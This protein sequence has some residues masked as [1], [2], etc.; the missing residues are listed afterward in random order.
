MGRYP[1]VG[2]LVAIGRYAA[3]VWSMT[4]KRGWKKD[5]RRAEAFWS[6]VKVW[7]KI[8][9][10]CMSL[11]KYKTLKIQIQ[12]SIFLFLIKCTQIAANYGSLFFT[13]EVLYVSRGRWV[14]LGYGSEM[15]G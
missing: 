6:N 3:L 11:L 13:L 14:A 8:S 1:P 12:Y 7:F 2:T 9:V 15:G 5:R 4:N 10:V